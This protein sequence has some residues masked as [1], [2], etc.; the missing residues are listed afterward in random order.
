M[1]G[2]DLSGDER[3]ACGVGFIVSRKQELSHRILQLGLEALECVEHRGACG[4]DLVT[5]DGAGIMTEIPCELLGIEPGEFAVASLL[6]PQESRLRAKA[7]GI[8]EHVLEYAGLSVSHYREVPV[9]TSVLGE[10][11]RVSMPV[12]RQAFIRPPEYATTRESFMRLLYFTKKTLRTK[13]RSAGI[14]GEFFFSSCSPMT[15]VYKGLVRSSDLARLYP[16]LQSPL[17]KTRYVMFH[18]RFSTNTSTGWDK[19]QPFSMIAHN[20]EINTISGNRAWS[21]SR[22]QDLGLP[23]DELLT[24]VGI[25]D[26]GSLN[27]MVEALRYRSDIAFPEDILSVMIP[28]AEKQSPFYRFWSR[29]LEPWDGPAFV[30]FCDGE[31]VG[32]RLDRNGFRPA[33]WSM[34]EDFF[35]MASED[36][37]FSVAPSRIE[38]K[39][40]LAAGSGVSVIISTG[41]VCFEDPSHCPAYKGAIF[42]PRILTLEPVEDDSDVGI[43]LSKK[44]LF[45][46][47]HEDITN[48]LAPMIL[49]GKE[50]IGSMGNTAA[51]A[52]LSTDPRPLFDYFYQNFAQ[53]TNPPVDYIRETIV[54]NLDQYI[55]RKP[56]VFSTKQLLPPFTCLGISSP[57][58]SLAGLQGVKQYLNCKPSRSTV[59]AVELDMLWDASKGP[60]GLID[61]LNDLGR[62]AEISVKSGR[63]VLILSD[64]KAD[65]SMLPIPSLL[66][67]SSLG[68]R[69]NASGD[70]LRASFVVDTADVRA[71]HHV[72][73]LLGFGATAVCPYLALALARDEPPREALELAPD[74]RE[75]NLLNAMEMG[76]LKIM[77]KM[78][79]SVFRSYQGSQLFTILGL[80][81]EIVEKCFPSKTSIIGGVGFQQVAE[82]VMDNAARYSSQGQS[83]KLPNSLIYKESPKLDR[84]I[85]HSMTNR[86][87]RLLQQIARLADE[88]LE[89]HV[90]DERSRSLYDEY[91]QVCKS[92]QPTNIRHFFEVLGLDDS[93][94]V[95]SE[96]QSVE[97][98]CRQFG[99]GA[100]SFGAIS[101]E[102]QADIFVAMKRLSARSNSG[103][104]GENPHYWSRG[105]AASTKQIASGR[106]G[107][108]AQ[109]LI[110]GEEI[111][112]KIAQ[113]AKPGEGGQLMSA[114]VNAD[115][116]RARHAIEGI[117]LIS[118]PPMHDIYS[119][120]DLRE[121][122]YELKQLH[123]EG[124]ISVKLVSGSGIGTIA[125]GVAKA[126]A[127][128]IHIS[129]GDGGTGAASLSS[130]RHAGLPWEFGLLEVHREL[131]SNKLRDS[132]T[133]RV[134]GGLSCGFDIV[135]AAILGAQEF[136]FGKLMLI[137]EG[138][139][140]ARICEK[141]TCP[142]GIA[143]HDPK[144]KAK[145]KGKPEHVMQVV[146]MVAHDTREFLLQLG[147]HSLSQLVG[148]TDLLA[149]RSCFAEVVGERGLDLS[150]FLHGPRMSSNLTESGVQAGKPSQLGDLNERIVSD[151]RSARGRR[152]FSYQ[153]GN[154][155]RAVLT[156]FAGVVARARH[157]RHLRSLNEFPGGAGEDERLVDADWTFR[158]TGCAGQGFGAFLDG[159][160]NVELEGAANDSVCKSMARG[161]VAIYPPTEAGYDAPQS[162]I[163]GNCALYGATGG[164]LYVHGR[165]GD[166][167]AVR[168]SGAV[169]VVEGVGLHACEYM[170]NGAVIILGDTGVNVGAGMTGGVLYIYDARSENVN[171]QY[172]SQSF[173][174]DDDREFLFSCLRDYQAKTKSITADA[175]LEQWGSVHKRF[176]KFVA[177]NGE[178]SIRSFVESVEVSR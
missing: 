83:S 102:A 164:R 162:A 22:E 99:G 96:P 84:G 39:G 61:A 40:T 10:Q 21:Y 135:V 133:L 95:G 131:V 57:I 3:S 2:K 178:I 109:Y 48:V 141:N 118:P 75:H 59:S 38:Q 13:Q 17:F 8:F 110:T 94:V 5:G 152:E 138:C 85:K 103:E 45:G 125:V 127:D 46:Y 150:Y 19:A 74:T 153:I 50:P 113:G 146:R 90:L 134:D 160:V 161:V 136:D 117:D 20:G 65:S 130:M 116:A 128:V 80:G 25:S 73:L 86:Q 170:T 76:L 58:L 36:G 158:F 155:D 121:L 42:D 93:Q 79:I 54:T 147:A 68:N 24:H 47:E 56:N 111:Q 156:G 67:V 1:V 174:D 52:V 44:L 71:T 107:V 77:S 41:E 119:I 144:F 32:G 14:V 112:I 104:G 159:E 163:I 120:E 139:V 168:N 51:L 145:Y 4:A 6:L 140:M 126:G 18:R 142:T 92:Q 108:T 169:A 114:K 151:V 106:F 171:H 11:A 137:A 89:E 98:I 53:V 154:R 16:D 15:V 64:R 166:R 34:C 66:V 82:N 29:A 7:I 91:L 43:D 87:S 23:A 173:L 72:A 176:S 124:R 26:S 165:T 62:Q 132:V 100:M 30:T 28:P 88:N 63:T 129:G 97:S 148:R 12:M 175:I 167:F 9:D 105:I 143:T 37:V 149:L 60:D 55:G 172:I 33:R 81:K 70:R 78:G 69:L 123:P 122:I 157:F 177:R 115:I 49:T 31:T 101:A 35:Y 27:E